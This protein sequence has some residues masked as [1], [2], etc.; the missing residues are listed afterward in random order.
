MYIAGN[1]ITITWI[2]PPTGSP[3]LASDYDIRF[4]GGN[5]AATYTNNGIINYVPPTVNTSGSLQYLFTPANDGRYKIFLTCGIAGAYE[6]I[7]KKDFWVFCDPSTTLP[8]TTILAPSSVGGVKCVNT[9]AQSFTMQWAT[10]TGICLDPSDKN[11]IWF[12]GVQQNADA[13]V[14]IGNVNISTGVITEFPNTVTMSG[15]KVAGAIAVSETG[16]VVVINLTAEASSYYL[17]YADAPYTN[18]TRSTQDFSTVSAGHTDLWY[19]K[20]LG[21]YWWLT[22]TNMGVSY[23][24]ADFTEQQID[25]RGD[26]NFMEKFQSAAAVRRFKDIGAAG[27]TSVLFGWVTSL[28]GGFGERIW[29]NTSA[30]FPGTL[31][32]D[33]MVLE[34]IRGVYDPD[35]PSASVTICGFAPDLDKQSIWTVGAGG[36]VAYIIQ[37]VNG[38]DF[39]GNTTVNIDS[40]LNGNTPVRFFT[41][42]D[43]GKS[44]I[45]CYDGGNWTWFES[46]NMTTWVVSTDTRIVSLLWTAQSAK[47]LWKFLQYE[48]DSGVA[49]IE[50]DTPGHDI[51]AV[52]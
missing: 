1:E 4:I 52:V 16:R 33:W 18:W 23:D 30:T 42:H 45:G 25:G 10:M 51:K 43:F 15:A 2:I 12:V 35:P 22:G 37:A 6:V 32:E 17:Y 28:G 49:W 5:L 7:D 13:E 38:R 27:N 47:N 34:G 11:V 41:I 19:D 8:S 46:T 36:G 14:G 40:Q 44:F 9:T 21:L 20:Q 48:D 26:N 24:G 31:P 3:L 50:F 39:D 29:T